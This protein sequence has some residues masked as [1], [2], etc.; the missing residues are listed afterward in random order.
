ME[1]GASSLCRE[2]GREGRGV[3]GR[4]ESDREITMVSVM[5]SPGETAQSL[6][7]D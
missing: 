7:T 4:Q 1:G 3:G 6:P 5:A 2:G